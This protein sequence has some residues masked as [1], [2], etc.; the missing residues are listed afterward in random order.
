VDLLGDDVASAD[1]FADLSPRDIEEALAAMLTVL[2]HF[3]RTNDYRAVF[4]HMYYIITRNVRDEIAAP[5]PDR[6]VFLDPAWMSRLAG[7]FATLYFRSLKALDRPGGRE[8]AWKLAHGLAI[9]KRSSVLQDM[10]L[11]ITAHIKYDLA[12]AL[13]DNIREHGD[14]LKPGTLLLR[15]HD[16]DSANTL[17]RRSIAEIKSVVPQ[18]YGGGHRGL[19]IAGVPLDELLAIAI[20]R[21][22]RERVWWDAMELLHCRDAETVGRVMRRMDEESLRVAERLAGGRSFMVRALRF[23]GGDQRRVDLG[24]C[25]LA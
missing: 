14:H 1:G 23:F 11:G 22:H 8:R 25:A 4:L 2:R 13:A 24:A 5:N 19:L 9:E 12:V 20:V 21:Y 7:K 16:H 6:P 15:K 3:R 18:E 17:L 10:V